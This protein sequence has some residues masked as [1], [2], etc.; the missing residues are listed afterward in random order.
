LTGRENLDFFG[1]LYHIPPQ[2]RKRRADE[3]IRITQ[4]ER[5]H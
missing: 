3:I 5:H 1:A 2:A 4:A